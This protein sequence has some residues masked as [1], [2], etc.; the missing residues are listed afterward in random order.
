MRQHYDID[1]IENNAVISKSV[2]PYSE[3]TP[4]LPPANEV[5]GG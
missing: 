4:L 3:V 2:Q 5:A 1:L